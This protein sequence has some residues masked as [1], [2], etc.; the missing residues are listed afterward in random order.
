MKKRERTQLS[1][2]RNKRGEVITSTTETQRIV[3]NYYEQLYAK[4]L[5]DL[6]KMYKFVETF[7]FPK[8]NQEE[9]ETLNRLIITSENEAVVKKLLALINPGMDG[10]TCEFYQ[11]FKEELTPILLKLLQKIQE[12]GRFTNSF[13]EASNMLIPK[14]G[15]DTTN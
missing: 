2:I 9:A 8:L 3:R 12:E 11:T 15:R 5:D 14:S 7:S 6:G 4:K 13:Y 10:F 1:K